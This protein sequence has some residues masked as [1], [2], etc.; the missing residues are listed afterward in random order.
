MKTLRI[1]FLIFSCFGFIL[2]CSEDVTFEEQVDMNL[3]KAE[4]TAAFTVEPNGVNDTQNLS[5]AFTDAI[6][7]GSGAVVQLVE[8]E[9]HIGFIEVQEFEGIFKGAGKS[10]TIITALTG[11]DIEPLVSQNLNTFLLKF[12]GGDVYMS[13]MTIR[14]PEGVLTTSGEYWLEG[15]VSFSARSRVYV[16]ESD[17]IKAEVNNVDFIASQA[18]GLWKSNCN[19]GLSAGF[20]SRFT[21]LPEGWPLSPTDITITNCMF[22]NFDIYG[23]VIAYVNDG[24]VTIGTNNKS[25]IFK[26]NS[27]LNYG[28]GSSIS[29]WHNVN[30]EA[31]LVNNSIDVPDGGFFGIEVNSS[32][33][34]SWLQDVP[35]TKISVFNIEKNKFNINESIGAILVVDNRRFSYPDEE[36]ML[37]QVKNNRLNL[38]NGAF[39]GMGF[40]NNSGLVIRNN[41]FAGN[42]QYGVRVFG[43]G[44][45]HNENGLMLGN[46]FST[47]SFS[48]TV[49]LLNEMTRNWTVVGGNLGESVWDYGENNI[50]TGFNNNTSDGPLGQ[51]IVDNLNLMQ[52]PM[53]NLKGN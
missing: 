28:Y 51:T 44:W 32:A 26:N 10:K 38:G 41:K 12:V 6:N 31:S 15:L 37:L 30:M 53:H 7:Y 48:Q 40:F 43:Q 23:V 24:K 49:L 4:T 9:Y 33:W 16:S 35:Q 14:T 22:D 19:S 45:I 25:N 47:A 36:P 52:R 50:I 5:D 1:I 2:S 34:L 46:N 39:T 21:Q 42:A 8:G 29:F 13:D 11:L 17:Y 20:D 18:P 27:T 3:R